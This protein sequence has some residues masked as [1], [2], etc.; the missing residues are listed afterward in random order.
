MAVCYWPGL[1]EKS[2]KCRAVVSCPEY[3]KIYRNSVIIKS[4]LKKLLSN[5]CFHSPLSQMTIS[6]TLSAKGPR[7][8]GFYTAMIALAWQYRL[9]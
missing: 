1:C 6:F 7:L 3:E 4:T 8:I 2:T 9:S 5:I